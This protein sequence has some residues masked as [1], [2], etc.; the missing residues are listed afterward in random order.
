MI[1]ILMVEHVTKSEGLFG[2]GYG[3]FRVDTN[4]LDWS[5]WRRFSDFVWLR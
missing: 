3:A 1:D 4:P 5:V 2:T